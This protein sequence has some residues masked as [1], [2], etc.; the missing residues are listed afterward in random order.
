MAESVAIRSAA[1]SQVAGELEQ[2][3]KSYTPPAIKGTASIIYLGKVH[4]TFRPLAAV[5]VSKPPPAEVVAQL[6]HAIESAEAMQAALQHYRKCDLGCGFLTI[7]EVQRF[8][9]A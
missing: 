3:V 4:I 8:V 9:C 6:V 5:A 7:Q 2:W 1:P